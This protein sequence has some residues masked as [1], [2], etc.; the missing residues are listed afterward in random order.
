MAWLLH[1]NLPRIEIP[2]SNGSPLKWVKFV[3]KFREI[4]HNY[5][6]LKTS[7]KLHYLQQHISGIAKRTI[8]GF[9]NKERGTSFP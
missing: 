3:I 4:V 8:L 1:Q 6:Q 7:Q 5:V 9:S 2:T